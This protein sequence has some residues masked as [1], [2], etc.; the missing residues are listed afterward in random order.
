MENVRNNIVKCRVSDEELNV[1]RRKVKLSG[2]RNISDFLRRMALAGRIIMIDTSE[3][4]ESK[5]LIM[6]ISKNINQIALRVNYQNTIYKD[7]IEEMQQKID[8]IQYKLADIQSTLNS[9]KK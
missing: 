7:D 5:H 4:S 8:S 2:S 6:T 1:I 3:I 9:L